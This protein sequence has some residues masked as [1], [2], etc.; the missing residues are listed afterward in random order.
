DPEESE[1]Y[2]LTKTGRKVGNDSL[3]Y[4]DNVPDCESEGF[5]RFYDQANDLV[6]MLNSEGEIQIPA[7]Y[8]GLG[9]VKNGMIPAL[10][11]AQRKRDSPDDE[12]S[13]FEGG[14][15]ILIDTNSHILIEYFPYN[16]KQ[17]YYPVS[18][19]GSMHEDSLWVKSNAKDANSYAFMEYVTAFENLF[20]E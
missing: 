16:H 3:Y 13:H 19:N 20:P 17:N 18:N 11:G 9:R 4:F 12:H 7:I 1:Y 2:F 6:G 14:I 5:I 8:N 10:K 15:S